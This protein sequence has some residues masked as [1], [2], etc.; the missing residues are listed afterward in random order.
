M[1][2]NANLSV[3]VTSSA[4]MVVQSFQAMMYRE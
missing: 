4:F 2:S 1:L 3:F